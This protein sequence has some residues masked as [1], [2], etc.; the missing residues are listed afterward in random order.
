MNKVY[1]NLKQFAPI[2]SD[3]SRLIISYECQPLEDGVHATWYEIYFYKK[4]YPV[5]T[6]EMVKEAVIADINAQTDEKILSGFV[7]EEKPVWLSSE[8]QFNFK[9]AYDLAIQTQGQNLP[10]KFKLGE[11][12]VEIGK[13]KYGISIREKQPVYYTFETVEEF[14]D[15]YTKAI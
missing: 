4:P 1:G 13:D 2:R 10:L 7:W 15:F 6:F 3:R 8:N 12:E 5:V 11:V 14:T 9:A